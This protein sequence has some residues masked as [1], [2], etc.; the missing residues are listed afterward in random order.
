MRLLKRT[1]S[2]AQTGI[3]AAGVAAAIAIV[4]VTGFGS[5]A[6]WVAAATALAS[7]WLAII[8]AAEHRLPNPI[9][10]RLAAGVAAA[11]LVLGLTERDLAH[12]ARSIGFG[13][14]VAAVLM[15]VGFANLIGMGD[16]KF[17]GPLTAV[18]AWFGETALVVGL[19][20]TLAT[21]SAFVIV[22]AIQVGTTRFRVA[23][24]PFMT[25]GFVAG[26]LASS[27]S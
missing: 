6:G 25:L 20:A 1:L 23:F 22:R 24:G 4:A 2:T 13:F 19:Y 3:G 12:T 11:L 26:V 17:S 8:D 16:A 14:A 5:F 18:L 10:L 21:A 27:M 7:T 15:L 9:V